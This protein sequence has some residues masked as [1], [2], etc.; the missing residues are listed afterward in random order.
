MLKAITMASISC[1]INF[2]SQGRSNVAG[3]RLSVIVRSEGQIN[4]SVRKNEEKVADFVKAA[5][6]PKPKVKFPMDGLS[7]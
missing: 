6:L 2:A 7:T 1:R 3:R 5:E 4:P